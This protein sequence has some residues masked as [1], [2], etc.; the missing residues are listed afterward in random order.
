MNVC[1]V[2]TGNACR[3]PFAECVLRRMAQERPDV[4]INVYSVGTLRCGENPR[5]SVMVEVASEMG[6]KLDGVTTYMSREKL[7]QADVVIVFTQEHRNAV[8]RELDYARWNRIILF[9]K[10]SFGTD[11]DVEDPHFQSIDVYRRVA[12]HIESGCRY[13]LEKIFLCDFVD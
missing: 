9:N 5:D 8:T 7:M 11:T 12:R 13:I 2:C 1:F 4:D 3:S 6:Y 10:I